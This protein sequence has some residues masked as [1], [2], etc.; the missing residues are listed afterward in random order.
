MNS[1]ES[2]ESEGRASNSG[3]GGGG[4]SEEPAMRSPGHRGSAS[5]GA[6]AGGGGG[7]RR[8]AGGVY[9]REEVSALRGIFKLYDAEETG[10]I[11]IKELEG[12]L[13][14][15]GYNPG[16]SCFYHEKK[17]TSEWYNIGR[18]NA[19]PTKVRVYFAHHRQPKRLHTSW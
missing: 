19:S 18:G 11:G 7:G 8:A 12:I 6:G 3:G 9:G 13:Q 15:V 1:N 4:G 14:K 5:A 10:T 17:G 2:R 16:E